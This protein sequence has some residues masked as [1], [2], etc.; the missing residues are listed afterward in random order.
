ME[1][2]EEDDKVLRELGQLH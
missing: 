1:I 2:C